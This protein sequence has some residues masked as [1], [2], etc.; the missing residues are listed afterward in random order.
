MKLKM[1]SNILKYT[2]KI[3]IISNHKSCNTDAVIDSNEGSFLVVPVEVV[4]VS[5]SRVVEG[6]TKVKAGIRNPE[7]KNYNM[8]T[9]HLLLAFRNIPEHPG[10]S[11]NTEKK[12]KKIKTKKK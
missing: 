7:T 1:G 11:R 3:T 5:E 10:T 8:E 9:K 6:S 4:A 2:L 12:L